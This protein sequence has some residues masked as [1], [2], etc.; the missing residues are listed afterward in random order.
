[1]KSSAELLPHDI[2]ALHL[3]RISDIKFTPREI[4]II[5]CL[6]HGKSV[7]GIA[8]FL[9]TDE[10]SIGAR[11][12]ETHINNLRRKISGSSKE[13]II[14]F[15]EDS[16]KYQ[17]VRNYYSSLLLQKGFEKTLRQVSES[18]Q[19]T[20][21]PFL[22]VSLQKDKHFGNELGNIL[23]DYLKL[24]GAIVTKNIKYNIQDLSLVFSN[25][26]KIRQN[27]IFV[28]PPECYIA[29]EESIG[30]DGSEVY[31]PKDNI[32]NELFLFYPNCSREEKKYSTHFQRMIIT[33]PCKPYLLFFKTLKH[34]FPNSSSIDEVVR[35]FIAK[36]QEMNLAK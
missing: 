31:I 7:K 9:S 19:S 3:I 10:R 21:T 26:N 4:D 27:L 11:S 20:D 22:I 12:V 16:N 13:S 8:K 36:Y 30:L 15:V 1:M 32:S 5:A 34:F 14:E 23:Y 2:Y 6:A 25:N 17:A 29:S 35:S 28:I 24:A 33:N 18:L